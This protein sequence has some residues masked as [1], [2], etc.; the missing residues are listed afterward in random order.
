MEK[1][2]Q[3]LTPARPNGA[4]RPG[5]Q[6]CDIAGDLVAAV[7]ER[8]IEVEVTE[9]L[10]A[11]GDARLVRVALG[12]LLGNAAKFTRPRAKARIEFGATVV[13]GT[14]AYF[15][16][17]NGVGFDMTFSGKLF[18]AFQRLHSPADFEGTGIGLATV[19]R[20]VSRHGGRTWATGEV[21]RGATF[22][23]T[24]S[25]Q[26]EIDHDGPTAGPG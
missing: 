10:A 15:V 26:K 19:H 2:A 24:L 21:D 13:E 4:R 18:N 6:A 20:V 1:H 14:T 23:F 22:Y 7:P 11:D 3:V 17:D 9:G 12:N 8:A 16:R 25:Q 5:A